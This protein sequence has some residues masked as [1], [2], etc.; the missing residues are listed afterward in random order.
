MDSFL[1]RHGFGPK[2]AGQLESLF[3]ER[4]TSDLKSCGRS[5]LKNNTE[6][7]AIS[8][9]SKKKTSIFALP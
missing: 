4:K 9:A 2:E 3:E 8:F 1:I 6:T 7:K 5:R